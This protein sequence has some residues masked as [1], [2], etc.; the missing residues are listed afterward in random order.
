MSLRRAN[1]AFAAGA[2]T[3]SSSDRICGALPP[4]DSPGGR[5]RFG[6]EGL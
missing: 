4:N 1:R 6:F 3:G 2:G 5:E